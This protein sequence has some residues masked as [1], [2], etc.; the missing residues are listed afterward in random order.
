[1]S[2][3]PPV[4]GPVPVA[5]PAPAAP[6]V[7][8]AAPRP[9]YVGFWRRVLAVAI[10]ALAVLAVSVP[11]VLAIYGRDY[12]ELAREGY[13]GFWDFAIEVP[14]PVLLLLFFWRR[15]G[16]TPG[17]MAVGARIVVASSLGR[18]GIGR[19]ILRYVAYLVSALPFGLGFLW[20][21]IDRRKQGWH[22][23]I[24]GTLVIGDGDDP[25]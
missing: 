4:A 2:A 25:V 17:K 14:L 16:A 19:C 21:A 22:D 10:D 24:A 3:L 11:L 12:G 23:K 5:E 18:P 7:A 9:E 8:K 15:Y 20:V 6:P 13:A 1:M